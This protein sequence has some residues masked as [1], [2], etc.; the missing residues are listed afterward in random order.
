MGKPFLLSFSLCLVLFTSACLAEKFNE[1]QL[2]SINALEPD[3]RVESEAGVIETWNSNR[4]ELQCA[5]VTVIK[6]TIDPLG[7]HLPSY[8]NYPQLT[9][10]LQGWLHLF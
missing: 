1:C 3:S 6:H 8:A 4:P 9:M 2:D 7:L 10:I 5:G